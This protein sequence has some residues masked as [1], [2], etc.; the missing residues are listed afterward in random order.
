MRTSRRA[1]AV[2]LASV[3]GVLPLLPPDARAGL[4]DDIKKRGEIVVASEAAFAPFEFVENGK[5][6]GYGADLLAL[7]MQH[8]RDCAK[9]LPVLLH[10]HEAGKEGERMRGSPAWALCW[11][12]GQSP[13]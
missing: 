2:G 6:V 4:L 1:C 5:I 8:P 10:G 13:R 3:L 9:Q 12:P 7:L 11:P